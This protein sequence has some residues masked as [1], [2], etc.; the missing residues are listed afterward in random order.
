MIRRVVKCDA[1]DI[2]FIIGAGA[3]RMYR[4]F[5][6]YILASSKGQLY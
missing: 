1:S 6:P 2:R 5:A 4:A 3:A